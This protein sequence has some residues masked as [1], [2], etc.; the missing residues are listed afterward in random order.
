MAGMNGMQGVYMQQA[1][2]RA[3]PLQQYA[4]LVPGGL[5]NVPQQVMVLSGGTV[6]L[7]NGLV[8]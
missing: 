1:A 4:G 2:A 5:M 7:G 3:V 8:R 6:A